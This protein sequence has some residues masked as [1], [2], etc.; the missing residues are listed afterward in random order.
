VIAASTELCTGAGG[1]MGPRGPRDR[2]ERETVCW[3]PILDVWEESSVS[4]STLMLEA[5][6]DAQGGA[7]P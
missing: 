6:R 2:S 5:N 7:A 3:S 1:G 4:L